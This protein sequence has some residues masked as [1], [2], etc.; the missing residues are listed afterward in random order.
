MMMTPERIWMMNEFTSSRLSP[1]CS[2]V[3]MSAPKSVPKTLP[4]PPKRLAPP[5]ITAAVGWSAK[6]AEQHHRGEAAE[7][8]AHDEDEELGAADA[9]AGDAGRGLIA[10]DGVDVPADH[11]L[12]EDQRD[13]R[14][15]EQAHDQGHGHAE[16]H[17]EAQDAGAVLYLGDRVAVGERQR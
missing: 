9:D 8:S 7:R 17:T 4:R 6:P 13:D 11:S 14:E 16:H 2:T 12:A 1:F 3:R 15:H 5:M 10:A